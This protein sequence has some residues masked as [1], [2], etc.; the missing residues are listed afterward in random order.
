MSSNNSINSSTF[1]E[2]ELSVIAVTLYLIISPIHIGSKVTK[3]LLKMLNVKT[4]TSLLLFTGLLFG[5]IYYFLIKFV[6]GPLYK[7]MRMQRFKV[8]GQSGG[9][10][11]S[12]D[13]GYDGLSTDDAWNQAICYVAPVS[14]WD[15]ERTL[16]VCED[17]DYHEGGC[18]R[19][20]NLIAKID[21]GKLR[22][23][24]PAYNNQ[25]ESDEV[26]FMFSYDNSSTCGQ[27]L[28]ERVVDHYSN[29]RVELAAADWNDLRLCDE[30]IY[31]KPG[32][33]APFCYRLTADGAAV[34]N[35]PYDCGNY[36]WGAGTY[37]TRGDSAQGDS[38]KCR[39]LKLKAAVD[40]II[41][42]DRPVGDEDED[43]GWWATVNSPEKGAAWAAWDKAGCVAGR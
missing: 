41:G 10:C 33:V 1:T 5:V 30:S 15:D 42:T 11:G 20:T 7:K 32:S 14:I 12:D 23:P 18:E 3:P 28:L 22:G 26:D 34:L 21:D 16:K 9:V 17:S 25:V 31:D 24:H 2:L 35:K 13:W 39:E 27:K 19:Y 6:L 40:E 37:N 4:P 36:S 8:G 38:I 43:R 29:T